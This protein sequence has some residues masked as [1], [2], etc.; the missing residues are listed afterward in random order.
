[1]LFGLKENHQR[2]Y[3]GSGSYSL[4]GFI[5]HIGRNMS[6][7]HYVAHVKKIIDGK[8][9]WV[10]FNDDKVGK[11]LETPLEYGYIYLYARD[12]AGACLL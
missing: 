5:S 2:K 8:E 4:V 7:G 3:F 10:I 9:T 1:L 12:D 11:S 6:H